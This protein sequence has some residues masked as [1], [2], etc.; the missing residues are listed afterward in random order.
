MFLWKMWIIIPKLSQLLLLIWSTGS[1]RQEKR[2]ED[3]TRE[4]AGMDF[5]GSA[6]EAEDRTRRKRIV[7]KSS[8]VPHRPFK[9]MG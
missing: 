4:C 6:R 8:V 7:V 9:V 1:G 5:N 3:I 2:W